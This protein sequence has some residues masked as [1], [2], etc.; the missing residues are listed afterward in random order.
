MFHHQSSFQ[1]R[2]KDGRDS[3]FMNL[4]FLQL[5]Y[6]KPMIKDIEPIK[7]IYK[8]VSLRLR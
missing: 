7:I 3:F 1:N 6:L 5:H 8:K 2:Q 4:F